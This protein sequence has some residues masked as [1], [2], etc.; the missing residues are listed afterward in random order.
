M[1]V[2]CGSKIRVT[3]RVALAVAG[4]LLGGCAQITVI[5]DQG[6]PRSEWKFGVLA[7][8]LAGSNENTI[9]HSMGVGLI[10]TPAGATLGY[11]NARIVRIGDECRIVITSKDLD[12]TSK[13][14]ELH[15]LMQAV[16]KACLT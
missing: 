15:R 4:F 16:H 9:V 8:D 12:A 6:P 13:D 14:P 5:S 1:D 10:S 7:I 11:A 3:L 2:A